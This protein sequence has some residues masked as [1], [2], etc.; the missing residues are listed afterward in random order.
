MRFHEKKMIYGKMNA[1]SKQ[2]RDAWAKPA[3]IL[4]GLGHPV[5]QTRAI[6]CP[7][8][9]PHTVIGCVIKVHPRSLAISVVRRQGDIP[10][11]V[12]AL[13]RVLLLKLCTDQ[14]GPFSIRHP[15]R[16]PKDTPPPH[17]HDKSLLSVNPGSRLMK[18]VR[19]L[20]PVFSTPPWA[21]HRQELRSAV[22]LV[23]HD[24][25]LVSYELS[26]GAVLH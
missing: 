8:M 26:D 13:A 15:Q 16:A 22:R 6:A 23:R 5:S 21:R 14:V 1:F 12:S 3:K 20:P 2:R 7:T 9:P 10:V 18:V 17:E 11:G 24:A 4:N 19:V 25:A